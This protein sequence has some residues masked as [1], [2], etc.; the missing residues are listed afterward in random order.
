M[1]GVLPVDS[2][3]QTRRSPEFQ[4]DLARLQDAVAKWQDSFS[5]PTS[6]LHRW[7]LRRV[8][9]FRYSEVHTIPQALQV[10]FLSAALHLLAPALV[11][12]VTGTWA[13][14]PVWSWFG[15]AILMGV[16]DIFGTRVHS[17]TSPTGE[18]LFE[19]PAAIDRDADL[20]ELLEFTRRWWRVR[21]TAPASVVLALAVLAA[22]AM[23]APDDFRA[24][25]V[26]SLVMVALLVH[27]F[28]EGQLMV[29]IALRFYV[30]ES[31]FLHRLSWLDPVASPPVQAM[32]HTWFASI[33]AGSPMLVVYGAAAAV[34][35]AP[36]SPDLLLV[37][38][39]GIALIGL[40]LSGVSVLSL[41]RSVQ[42]I[43]RHTRDA[44]LES[45]RERIESLQPQVRELTPA[46]TERLQ[47]LLGTYAAVRAAPTGP[48]GA[49]T[50]GHAVTALAVPALTF[51][52]AVMS[53][54]YAERLLN[55]LLP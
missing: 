12:T 25:H 40:V 42:R 5:A 38:L 51:L 33:G 55:Q 3:P 11:T 16:F 10:G 14:A 19:L 49:Q 26:G 37:P 17:E 32:F 52:L 15:V 6:R 36:E 45:L 53:E 23:A 8:L 18:R 35:I 47:G 46:E 27:E 9:G 43:V 4:A 39:A 50:F 1:T 31:R 22:T 24:F 7:L 48:S 30:R 44:T 29:F 34:L 2:G 20:H 54:V 21:N 28:I 41:R 13:G